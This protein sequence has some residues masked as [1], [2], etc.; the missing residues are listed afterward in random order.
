LDSRI[1]NIISKT[2]HIEG[3]YVNDP[4]DSG[5]ETNHGISKRSFPNVDIKNLTFEQAIEIGY[6]FYWT[7][8]K[9]C[10]YTNDGYAWK[11][12]D[13]CFNCGNQ[14]LTLVESV[15]TPDYIDT[16]DGVDDLIRSLDIH[17]EAIV[18]MVPRDER[19]L[20]GWENR[21]AMKYETGENYIS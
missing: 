15:V 7:P 6:A 3:G 9:L 16:D 14:A 4:K 13:I 20:K 2:I 5:G 17:Y 11:C 12:F 1:R 19:F 8:N 21:A 18:A 10:S